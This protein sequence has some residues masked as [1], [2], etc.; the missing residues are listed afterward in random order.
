MEL[1]FV[2]FFKK[3]DKIGKKNMNDQTVLIL[4]F[5]FFIQSLIYLKNIKMTAKWKKK[6]FH[7]ELNQIDFSIEAEICGKK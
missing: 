3:K 6:I 5:F 2:C 7:K 1:A 4:R